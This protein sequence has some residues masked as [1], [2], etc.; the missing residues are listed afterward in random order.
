[1]TASLRLRSLGIFLAL[2]ALATSCSIATDDV[3]LVPLIGSSTDTSS[4][5]TSAPGD[6]HVLGPV[7]ASSHWHAAYV[8]RICDD[9]LEP[10]DSSDDP[11]GI[12]SHA[13]GLMHIHPFFEESGYDA[14]TL[15]L[16]ADA[17]GL[18][19]ASGELTLPGGGT[20]RDGDDCNGV[21]GRVF[22]DKWSDPNPESAVERIFDSPQDVRYLADGELYQIAFAPADSPPVVPPAISLLSQVSN[23]GP[24]P[25]PWV[26]IDPAATLDDAQVWQISA[27]TP[28]P[29]S[30]SALPERVLSGPVR[31]F[32][33]AGDVVA[34][35]D[36]ITSARAVILNRRPA[37]DM[38][39][40]PDVQRLI[41]SHFQQTGDPFGLAIE[42]D[43]A[44]VSAPLIVRPPAVG[45][46]LALS[47]G[48]SFET[49][50]QLA[51]ILNGS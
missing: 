22:V 6:L 46:R 42:V 5:S 44:V 18:S 1:M 34:G 10:F 49:A 24:A 48:F 13:D 7:P 8:V 47:G 51:A 21:P 28:E 40:G 37:I 41:A 45:D 39:I 32:E 38:R 31:C 9:V 12:H 35:P 25:D 19:L 26:D 43:G 4:S 23:L 15:G 27:V 16:F 33:P 14:A 2:L 29:C 36:A 11:L 50:R 17:M 3:A 30:A 20:W